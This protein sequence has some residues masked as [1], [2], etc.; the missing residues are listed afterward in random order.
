LGGRTLNRKGKDMARA[1]MS[2]KLVTKKATVKTVSKKT[3]VKK[4]AK[5]TAGMKEG[6]KYTCGV[7]GLSVTVDTACG[8][9]ETS[10][11]ICCEK[12]MRM[13]R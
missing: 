3:A 12:P 10:H 7:C 2:E 11:L 13:K 4:T 6:S 1:K 5:K 8:C 9:A